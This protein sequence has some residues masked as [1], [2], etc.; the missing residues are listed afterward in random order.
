MGSKNGVEGRE[1]QFNAEISRR[2]E[3]LRVE[4]RVRRCDLAKAAGVSAAL[5]RAYETGLTRWP[6]F[7][8]RLVAQYF[9]VSVEQLIPKMKTYVNETRTQENLFVV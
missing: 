8:V 3:K 4:Q 9:D 2:V 5:L 1:V 7:R 6:V